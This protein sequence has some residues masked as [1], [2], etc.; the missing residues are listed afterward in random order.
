MKTNEFGQVI[1][2][3][4]PGFTPGGL[5][6]ATS[7]EG[8]YTRLEKLKES[9]KEALYAVYGPDT[10]AQMWTYLAG[11]SVVNEVEWDELFERLLRDSSKFYYVILDKNTQKALGTF[12]L[13]R[14]DTANRVV[15]IG[16]V[17]YLPE[18]QRTRIATEAQYLMARYV[19]EEMG[20][21]RY[22]WKCDALNEPSKCAAKRLG[23]TYE[24]RFR[25]A[26]VYKGRTRDT[27]WYSMID[28]EWPKLKKRFEKWLL[29]ENFNEEGVQYRSLSQ[30]SL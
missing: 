14:L 15:E 29:P 3:A 17:T 2:E 21:R 10:P 7:I 23:F 30:Q 20:Y 26:V 27:D 13:M 8:R 1:G 22:E 16:S 9:H 11:S 18:L 25:Q 28:Q 12:A 5:P 24:G 6:T 19:F 4:V